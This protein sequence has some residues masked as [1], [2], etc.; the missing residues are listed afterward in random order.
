MSLPRGISVSGTRRQFFPVASLRRQM[1]EEGRKDVVRHLFSSQGLIPNENKSFPK[2]LTFDYKGVYEIPG[3]GNKYEYDSVRVSYPDTV[4]GEYSVF[5]YHRFTLQFDVDIKG[6]EN[7]AGFVKQL[8][9][10]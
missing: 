9:S 5:L 2:D 1:R 10:E 6:S 4:E 7:V 8:K 3:E